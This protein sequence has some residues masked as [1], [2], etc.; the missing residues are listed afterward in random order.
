VSLAAA[1]AIALAA[2][3]DRAFGEPPTRFHPVA[4]LGRLVEWLDASVPD[5]RLAGVGIAA[6]TPAG[7]GLALAGVV[8]A[9]AAAARVTVGS[10][11]GVTATVLAAAALFV[12][13]SHRML[14]AVTRDVV[15]LSAS[16]VEE[17]RGELRALA[18]RDASDLSPAHVRSAAVESA[19]ENLADGLVA[20]LMGFAVGALA[21]SGLGL[22]TVEG[23]SVAAGVAGWVKAV[24]TLDS[25][26][27]YRHRIAG[28]APA[29][30]DDAVMW[31]PAR[32]S[33]VLLLA[34]GR[35]T[36]QQHG[37]RRGSLRAVW[38]SVRRAAGVPASPNSGWPMASLGAVL[39]CRL[40]K[41]G[42]YSLHADRPLPTVE[43]AQAGVR[44]VSRAGWLGIGTAS[45]VVAGIGRAVPR[46]GGSG[47]VPA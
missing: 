16:D 10:G 26:L 38:P 41:P 9:G 11:D 14:L 19:A 2:A 20:P 17:A 7:F 43:V 22:A 30:L 29:R 25:M 36:P 4:W 1:G 15:A 28:W 39:D 32:A 45:V 5:T 8:L 31:L 34:V 24:N 3:A 12:C 18:G 35:L 46:L 33:A 13:S 6:G 47:V 40:E 44:V 27:G 23:L 21:A 42:A 37:R